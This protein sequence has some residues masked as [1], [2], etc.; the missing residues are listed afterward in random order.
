MENEQKILPDGRE[1]HI[2]STNRLDVLHSH[3]DVPDYILS[4]RE[5]RGILSNVTKQEGWPKLPDNFTSVENIFEQAKNTVT[6]EWQ[7]RIQPIIAKKCVEWAAQLRKKS[8]DANLLALLENPDQLEQK[9]RI[10]QFGVLE[11]LRTI[12][13]KAWRELVLISSERQLASIALI[14]HWLQEFK[15]NHT[16]ENLQKLGVESVEEVEILIEVGAT[17]GKFIDQAYVKQIELSDAPN[18]KTATSFSQSGTLGVEYLY[19]MSAPVAHGEKKVVIKSYSEVFPFEWE[20]IALQL[21]KLAD[22]TDNLLGT[23]KLDKKYTGLPDY[24]RRMAEVYTSTTLEPTKLYEEW[25]SLMRQMSE[26]AKNGCPIMLIPQASAAIAAEA[27]KVD[28]ELRVGFRTRES[29]EL[30]KT[31]EQFRAIAQTLLNEQRPYLDKDQT[32]PPV[33]VN[34]QPFAFGPNVYWMTQG[35]QGREK[36]VIH[37]NAI[38]DVAT[39]AAHP[40]L[41]QMFVDAPSEQDFKSAYILSTSLHEIGHSIAPNEDL[42]IRDRVGESNE[43]AVLEELKADTYDL[44]LIWEYSQK[45]LQPPIDLKKQFMTKMADICNYLK[46]RSS[47]IGSSGERYFYDGIAFLTQLFEKG[48]L[49]KEGATYRVVDHLAGIQAISELADEVTQKYLKGT[50]QEVGEYVEQIRSKTQWQPVADFLEQLR[51]QNN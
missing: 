15:T 10:H 2:D 39:S 16:A 11:N 51:S 24:M 48:I 6:Q 29:I 43:S 12:L 37:T 30:E 26:L 3:P 23:G 17:L 8:G 5:I 21:K 19:E 32:I 41:Q 14:R 42:S 27:N 38:I 47:E 25:Q 18:G 31:L 33:L 46:N 28:V 9:I 13:P 34:F 1:L 36:I 7:S 20:K 44:K 40:L 35:E 22:K 49:V 4:A 50:P 45:G